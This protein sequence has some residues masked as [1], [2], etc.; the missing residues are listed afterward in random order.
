MLRRSCNADATFQPSARCP[1]SSRLQA[2]NIRV[3]PQLLNRI[4]SLMCFSDTRRLCSKVCVADGLPTG[5]LLQMQGCLWCRKRLPARLC[6]QAVFNSSAFKGAVGAADGLPLHF[7][8]TGGAV[9][10]RLG[11]FR[12]RSLL[13]RREL[14]PLSRL[15]GKIRV[16]TAW[17]AECKTVHRYAAPEMCA[18]PGKCGCKP[19]DH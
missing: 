15:L 16:R 12:S 8:R 3:L 11:V 5:F 6:E 18:F 19:W 14:Y 2:E 1:G 17:V 4:A 7:L 13:R 10:E 9:G